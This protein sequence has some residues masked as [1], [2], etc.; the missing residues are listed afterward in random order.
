MFRCRGGKRV[1]H[2]PPIPR[3]LRR[4]WKTKAQMGDDY[5]LDSIVKPQIEETTVLQRR[6]HLHFVRNF[7]FMQSNEEEVRINSDENRDRIVS[8]IVGLQKER[9]DNQWS[10]LYS[11]IYL[12]TASHWLIRIL[13]LPLAARKNIYA[14]PPQTRNSYPSS[15]FFNTQA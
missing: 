11:W 12:S 14:Q 5:G 8:M 15:S 13:C 1:P 4:C 3:R 6:S 7:I 2:Y 9:I 10:F